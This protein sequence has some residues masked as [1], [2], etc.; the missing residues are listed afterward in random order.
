MYFKDASGR[1]TEKH[2]HE[3]VIVA[4]GKVYTLA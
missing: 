4:L 2:H 3:I 1:R